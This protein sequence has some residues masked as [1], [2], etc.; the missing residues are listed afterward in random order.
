VTTNGVDLAGTINFGQHF[1]VYDAIS[2]NKSTYDSNYNSGISG[3]NPVVVATSGK[4]VPDTPDWL[5]KFIVS[6][7]FGPF[8]AQLN[9]DYVGRRYATYLNDLSVAP[10]FVLGAEASYEFQVP[11]HTWLHG[12]K[13]SVNVTNLT[14]TKGISTI[15]VTSTSGGYQAYPL[16]PVMGFVTL[17]GTF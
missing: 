14:N 7:N 8:E 6:T 4:W 12:A 9:G 13:L 10:T 15:V 1:H 16:A 2:Y 3:G 17:E 5:E 11:E